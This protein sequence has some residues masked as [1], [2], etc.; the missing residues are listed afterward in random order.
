MK[1]LSAKIRWK[2]VSIG[3]GIT[4]NRMPTRLLSALPEQPLNRL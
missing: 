1:E 2:C 4:V 3:S